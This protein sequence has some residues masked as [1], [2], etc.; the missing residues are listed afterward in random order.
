M[1]VYPYWRHRSAGLCTLQG[2]MF[3]SDAMMI[4]SSSLGTA[5]K[6][7]AQE[8]ITPAAAAVRRHEATGTSWVGPSW[9]LVSTS[10]GRQTPHFG[11]GSS[12]F[13]KS[14]DMI[15]VCQ[16]LMEG[17]HPLGCSQLPPIALS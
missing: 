5:M 12:P 8:G 17:V 16:Q 14:V 6:Q 15:D 7:P 13:G 1:F 9:P 10:V 11:M 2:A 4:P 3:V